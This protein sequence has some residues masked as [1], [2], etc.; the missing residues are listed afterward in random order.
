MEFLLNTQDYNCYATDI[1]TVTSQ[2]FIKFFHQKAKG[3]RRLVI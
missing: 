2:N 3:L 1:S